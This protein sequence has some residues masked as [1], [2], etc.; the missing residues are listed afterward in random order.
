MLIEIAGVTK[1]FTEILI[2]FEVAVED[3]IQFAFDVITQVTASLLFKAEEK[4]EPVATLLP[5]TFH[6]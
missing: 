3:V 6:W 2:E 1:G 5:F 4:A